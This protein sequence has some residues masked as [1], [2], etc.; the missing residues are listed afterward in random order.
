VSLTSVLLVIILNLDQQLQ[1]FSMIDR[2]MACIKFCFSKF[3]LVF[4]DILNLHP[5]FD[6]NEV[7]I[8]IL[9]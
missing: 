3:Y 5:E 8:L 1:K 6:F 2:V 7:K 9:V 4:D